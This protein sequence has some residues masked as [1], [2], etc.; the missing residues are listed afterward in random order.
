MNSFKWHPFPFM[1]YALLF[2]L[3]ILAADY[4]VSYLPGVGILVWG[5]LLCAAFLFFLKPVHR[6]SLWS[7]FALSLLLIGAGF[8]RT[9]QNAGIYEEQHLI[10]DKTSVRAYKGVVSEAVY[11]SGKTHKVTLQVSE[12]ADSSSTFHKSHGKVLLFLQKDISKVPVYGDRL[13]VKGKPNRP[14]KPKNPHAFDYGK[15][16]ER[17]Q[18]YHTDYIRDGEFRKLGYKAPSLF[19]SQALR[20]RSHAD[21][22]L[23]KHIKTPE[24]YGIA[25][26]LLLG[27]RHEVSPEIREAYST[28]GAIHVLAVSGLHVGI[29]FLMLKLLLVK[30][31]SNRIGRWVYVGVSLLVLWL[32]AC[33]TGLSPSVLRAAT[34]FSCIV[35]AEVSDRRT[36]IYNTL[37]FSALL[38]LFFNPHLIFHIG[39]Q[40]S[41]LAVLAI[42]YLQPKFYR[43]FTFKN[44]FADKAWALLCVSVTAQ[45]GT[46]PISVY[47]FGQFPTH[48]WLTNLFV[49]TLIGIILYVGVAFLFLGSIHELVG[50]ILG[51]VLEKLIWLN[52]KIVLTVESLPVAKLDNLSLSKTE[53]IACYGLMLSVILLLEYRKFFYAFCGFVCTTFLIAS[54]S[55]GLYEDL[56]TSRFVIYESGKAANLTF[57]KKKK[58][59]LLSDESFNYEFDA[60]GDFRY[61]GVMRTERDSICSTREFDFI[62]QKHS[63]CASFFKFENL[64]ILY[65]SNKCGTLPPTNTDVLVLSRNAVNRPEEIQNIRYHYLVLDATNS[66][67]TAKGLKSLKTHFVKTDGAFILD[68]Q[69][70]K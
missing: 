25:A 11:F 3:G 49:I 23:R 1:R 41:Y 30:L 61:Y 42:V 69:K 4:T 2:A 26:A 33:I 48:F 6:S 7:A 34:M 19:M 32:Y 21:S 47:Y 44:Y 57:M 28:A 50:K 20:M 22:L 10:H 27:L 60:A 45:L 14:E 5:V 54:F 36:N 67:Y 37:G 24:T 66:Y 9:Q 40:L 8:T 56:N 63:S 43:L 55:F 38:L 64:R 15:F 17:Q 68:L 70:E 53:V 13:L 51:F 16:L 46:F 35:V 52:N 65:L 39:F 58:A 31:K 12:T 29:I 18:I 62:Q 59:V